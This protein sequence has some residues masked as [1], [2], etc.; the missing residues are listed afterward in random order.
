MI[1]PGRESQGDTQEFWYSRRQQKGQQSEMCFIV[2]PDDGSQGSGIY[3][4]N[5]PNQIRD[6]SEKQLVQEYV[7][8]PF[9]MKDQLKFDFRVYGVIKSINPLS[10]YVSREGTFSSRMEFFLSSATL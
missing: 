10:I 8:D 1:A 4:I 9:L 3:L 5:D 2:K 7:A 6:V